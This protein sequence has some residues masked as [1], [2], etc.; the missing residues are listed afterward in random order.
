MTKKHFIAMAIQF[1]LSIRIRINDYVAQRI[2]L[3]EYDLW[4]STYVT[5]I[6][7]FCKVAKQFNNNFD[8][9]YFLDFVGDVATERRDAQGKLTKKNKVA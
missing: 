9:E 3:D 2:S 1:G 6:N 5:A 4:Y 8:V 7:D